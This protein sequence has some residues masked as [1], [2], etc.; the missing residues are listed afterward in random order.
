MTEGL[1]RLVEELDAIDQADGIGSE[2][3]GLHTLL[4]RTEAFIRRYVYLSQAQARALALWVAH[5]WAIE[6]AEVTPYLSITSAEKRSGKTR[7]LEVLAAVVRQ[8]L[9]AADMT[10]AVLFRV[11]EE[12]RA[13]VLFD[14]VDVV[15]RAKSDKAEE[16]RGLLNAGY[17]RDGVALR[18]EMRGPKGT[19]RS[20]DVFGAKALAGIGQL[21][22]TVGDRS[23]P[24][25]LDRK[26]PGEKLERF[27][28]RGKREETAPLREGFEAWA[29]RTVS[30]LET[31]VPDLPD[32]LNDRQQD[33]WEPLLAIADAAGG[34]WPDVAR[35]ASLEL[36]AGGEQEESVGV[37][38]LSHIR[39]AFHSCDED[40]RSLSTEEI[41]AALVDNPDGPWA[42]WWST[43]SPGG[44][45]SS[46]SALAR[47][48]RVFGIQ[49][50]KI[51]IGER[52][53][54]GYRRQDF[55]DGWQR[56]LPEFPLGTGGTNGTSPVEALGTVPFDPSADSHGTTDVVA[57]RPVPPVPSVPVVS[58]SSDR[59]AVLGVGFVPTDTT[60]SRH[61]PEGTTLRSS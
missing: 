40:R 59:R 10:A 20:F 5:T 8:P 6:A 50:T 58:D 55:E 23:I 32:A 54:R 46:A 28:M 12:R 41:I 26:L 13:T 18:M 61:G 44:K 3:L 29:L 22:D 33:I 60:D 27:R 15:F 53:V 35:G 49:P 52:S 45:R 51:R 14:E 16:L 34:E 24:I 9:R 19:V 7:L 37:L 43:E 11:I 30:E 42:R 25:R 2:E 47:R 21:P 48:L 31:A 17:R 4:N 36:H 1:A 39:E 57:T 56:Y 38:L